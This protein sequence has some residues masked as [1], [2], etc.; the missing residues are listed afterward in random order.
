M[1]EK[2]YYMK[3]CFEE[4]DGKTV[5]NACRCKG[6]QTWYFPVRDQCVECFSHDM[7]PIEMDA[8][9]KLYTYSCIYTAPAKFHPPYAMGY[10]DF[11]NNLRTFGQ[12]DIAPEDFNKLKMDMPVRMTVGRIYSDEQGD[13]VYS[14][15]LLPVMKD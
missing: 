1:S 11:P 5:L 3:E 9:G 10:A 12:I 6:C 13:P 8:E 2:K 4:R 15:K 7:E 14:F